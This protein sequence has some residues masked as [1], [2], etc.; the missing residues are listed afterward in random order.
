MISTAAESNSCLPRLGHILFQTR[1]TAWRHGTNSTRYYLYTRWEITPT[2]RTTT[3]LYR[4]YT[5][6]TIIASIRAC[7]TV[8]GN[9]QTCIILL[10]CCCMNHSWCDGFGF[11]RTWSRTSS[12]TDAA[13]QA[14]D[15]S[16][17]TLCACDFD[18]LPSTSSL[19]SFSSV[20]SKLGNTGSGG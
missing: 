17:K 8:G 11:V 13:L 4:L 7:I 12:S 9:N 6:Y 3:R 10:Q 1:P 20:S 19:T 15:N 2:P 14:P 16:C 5:I 18:L